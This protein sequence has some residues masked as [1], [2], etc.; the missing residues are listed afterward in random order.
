ME[1]GDG[2]GVEGQQ[3]GQSQK[4]ARGAKGEGVHQGKKQRQIFTE[5]PG[6]KY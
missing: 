1:M 6:I 4:G 3:N 2:V 5:H